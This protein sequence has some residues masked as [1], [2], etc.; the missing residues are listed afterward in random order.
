MKVIKHSPSKV[1]PSDAPPKSQTCC[2]SLAL[3]FEKTH[4]KIHKETP[5]DLWSLRSQWTVIGFRGLDRFF[6]EKMGR[7]E[8]VTVRALFICFKRGRHLFIWVCLPVFKNKHTTTANHFSY[9]AITFETEMQLPPLSSCH[10]IR[11]LLVLLSSSWHSA[12]TI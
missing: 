9:C 5:C 8:A 10:S 3:S 2:F 6:G 1:F 11:A 7:G 4:L 12:R